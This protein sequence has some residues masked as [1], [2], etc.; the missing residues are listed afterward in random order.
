MSDIVEKC[1][2][3]RALLDEEDLFCANCG[4]ST[5]DDR[6]QKQY[7]TVVLTHHFEC[8]SCGA[9][10]SYDAQTQ[11][12]RCPYCGSQRLDPKQDAQ[13]WAPEK[14]IPFRLNR[15]QALQSLRNWLSQGMWRPGDLARRAA[16]SQMTPVYVPYWLFSATTHTF[17]NA[18]VP[19]PPGARG[20]WQPA[21]GE[22]RGDYAGL[23]VGA[24]ATLTA[25]ETEQIC[26]F[27][28]SEGRPWTTEELE[29]VIVE[30]G[31]VPRK[32]ARPLARRG[33]EANEREAIVL[34][35]L[36]GSHR[37]L[38]ANVRIENL[39]SEPILLPVWVMVY[40]YGKRSFRFL[41]NGQTG[42]ATGEAPLSPWKVTGAVLLVILIVFILVMLAAAN[43]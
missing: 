10:M 36:G 5:P 15:D 38:K 11:N 29:Q 42:K 19:A 31:S 33:F 7:G 30:S 24:S 14:V 13:V 4:K 37:N 26:P 21:S 17:W 3:C 23:L 16:V 12:L 2:V 41:I 27:D 22:H 25:A 35:S 28:V 39:V 32:F 20:Q 1:R 6:S 43:H 8:R 18:D 9:S 40:R 34:E